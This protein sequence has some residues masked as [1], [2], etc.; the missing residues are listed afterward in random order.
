VSCIKKAKVTGL[1]MAAGGSK[2]LQSPKQLLT[3]QSDYLINYIIK[4]A[5]ASKIHQLKV[6]LGSQ[7]ENIRKVI[8]SQSIGILINPEWESGLSS[9]IRTGITCLDESVDAALIMLVDQ[10]YISVELLNR[11]IDSF[12]ETKTEIVAPKVG[13]QQMTPVLFSKM[14]FPELLLLSGDKGAKEL[15]KKYPVEWVDWKDRK[16]LIDID[17]MEDYRKITNRTEI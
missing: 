12:I 3:W 1:L 6:I 10:P 14:L 17:S 9:S 7:A 16:L 5:T 15:L 8:T 11:M 4:I 2:R 13:R